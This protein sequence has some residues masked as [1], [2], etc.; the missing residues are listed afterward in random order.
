M[1]GTRVYPDLHV[2]CGRHLSSLSLEKY[3][4]GVCNHKIIVNSLSAYAVSFEQ[5]I[6]NIHFTVSA[7]VLKMG[8]IAHPAVLSFGFAYR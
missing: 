8:R 2:N 5:I 1:R 4:W 6:E 7:P 3:A